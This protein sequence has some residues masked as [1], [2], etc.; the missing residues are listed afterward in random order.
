MCFENH[1]AQCENFHI[2]RDINFEDCRS[3]KSAVFAILGAVNFVHLVIF[4]FQKV[5]K[6]M[7]TK[8]I[9]SKWVKMAD[10]ALQES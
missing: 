3:A 2:L 6:L 4:S 9:A 1:F 10:F 5:Q 7:K 8:F